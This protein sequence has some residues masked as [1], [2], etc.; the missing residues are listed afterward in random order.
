MTYVVRRRG[1]L[2]TVAEIARRGSGTQRPDDEDRLDER[3]YIYSL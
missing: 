3:H 2:D 1:S